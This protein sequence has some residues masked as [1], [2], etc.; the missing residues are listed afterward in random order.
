MKAVLLLVGILIPL[1]LTCDFSCS[2][3]VLTSNGDFEIYYPRFLGTWAYEGEWDGNPFF[4]CIDCNAL[5]AYVVSRFVFILA[6]STNFCPIKTDLS[7]N[8]V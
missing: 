6:F 7:G 3:N 5:I 1:A 8:T 2:R 4:T